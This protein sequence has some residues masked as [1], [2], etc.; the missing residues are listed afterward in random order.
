MLFLNLILYQFILKIHHNSSLTRT[1]HPAYTHHNYNLKMS[2][3]EHMIQA[4][5]NTANFKEIRA[6]LRLAMF[7]ILSQKDQYQ[8][9]NFFAKNF[10]ATEE[11]H[12]IGGIIKDYLECMNMGCTLSV[13]TTEVGG[14]SRVHNRA[15]IEKMLN[16][17]FTE[18]V[19]ILFSL[20]SSQ[21]VSKI[22]KGKI[23]NLSIPSFKQKNNLLDLLDRPKNSPQELDSSNENVFD[24]EENDDDDDDIDFQDLL[25]VRDDSPKEGQKI[26]RKRSL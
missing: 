18:G 10:L 8:T 3:K 23:P 16:K 21:P 6:K 14:L 19:P 1:H 25:K 5:T 24:N 22:P 4:L 9:T 13:F 15:T 7:Q 26:S 2:M 17:K 11:G 12:L 20:L